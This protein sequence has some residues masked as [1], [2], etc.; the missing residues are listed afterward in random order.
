MELADLLARIDSWE[1]LH[2]EFKVW[3]VHPDDLAA[4]LVAFANTDGGDLI[5][6][7]SERREIVG[8]GDP[9]RVAQAVDNVAANNYETT[10]KGLQETV[11]AEDARTALE[12]H[13]ATVDMSS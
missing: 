4:V 6:G 9:D 11:R 7:V 8:I 5:L 3:P 12:D 10:I 2:T 1:N 13:D